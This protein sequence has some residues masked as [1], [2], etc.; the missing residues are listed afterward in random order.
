M[1]ISRSQIDKLGKRIRAG[2]VPTLDEER[3]IQ[4]YQRSLI[5]LLDET[6][7]AAEF[8]FHAV[9][10]GRLFVAPDRP[11]QLR[12]I[13]AKLKRQSTSLSSIQDLWGCRVVVPR[14]TDQV[15]LIARLPKDD[16]WR[17][18]DRCEKPIHG[19]RA[20]HCIHR[21]GHAAV[22]LQVRT[23]LQHLWADFSEKLDSHAAP[24]VKYGEGSP[25]I[26]DMLKQTSDLIADI[27]SLELD[28]LPGREEEVAEIRS[29][30]AAIFVEMIESLVPG[31]QA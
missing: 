23:E 5:P 18:I 16:T 30:L 1:P 28:P 20:I 3:L 27:E 9:L 6:K 21:S 12:S 7:L 22:E 10:P 13:V 11:K 2:A 31:E 25:A 17:Y 8:A 29:K 4:E 19:Y 24:G 14:A 26:T 15:G